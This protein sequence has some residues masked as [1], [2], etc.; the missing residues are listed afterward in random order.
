MSVDFSLYF[1]S[2]MGRNLAVYPYDFH[3]GD[4]EVNPEPRT[5]ASNTFSHVPRISIVS[6]HITTRKCLF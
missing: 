6:L 2:F 1:N 4:V 3:S 5:K